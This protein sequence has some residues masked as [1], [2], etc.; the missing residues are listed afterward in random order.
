MARIKE[1][2]AKLGTSYYKFVEPFIINVNDQIGAGR[3]G[4]CAR[5]RHP[6]RQPDRSEDHLDLKHQERPVKILRVPA[7]RNRNHESTQAPN[8]VQLYDVKK[9]AN[10][11]Y[12]F[13]E[14]CDKGSLEDVLSSRRK[15]PEAEVLMITKQIIMGYKYL[16]R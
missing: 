3:T 5:R 8:I 7:Q 9:S 4:W 6:H 15:L 14:L 13:Q 11:I 10:N 2:A 1:E 12:L 16:H